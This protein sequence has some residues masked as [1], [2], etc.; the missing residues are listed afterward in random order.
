MTF[1]SADDE[2]SGAFLSHWR[3]AVHV[4]NEDVLVLPLSWAVQ[5]LRLT[6][7]TPQLIQSHTQIL[8]E[9]KH[10]HTKHDDQ[11]ASYGAHDI[12]G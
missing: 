3:Q 1:C 9:M 6:Q 7:I 10:A 11:E 8:E 5:G 2:D 12:H 4:L